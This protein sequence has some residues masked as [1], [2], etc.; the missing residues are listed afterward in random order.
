MRHPN[1]VSAFVEFLNDCATYFENL[2][3]DED[4]MHWAKTYNAKTLRD[5]GKCLEDNQGII[6]YQAKTTEWI[7]STFDRHVV[8]D[9]DERNHRFLEEALELVQAGNCTK[10]EAHKLVDY[11]F[12]RP[13]G[14]LKQEVGGVANT[15]ACLCNAYDIDLSEC[16]GV[17]YERVNTPQMREKIRLKQA[18]KPPMSPLPE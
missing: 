10:E 2:K 12:S 13:V 16:A 18:N 9:K 11:V 3:T 15:L 4:K 6:D 7:N 5:V 17:E 14:E 8:Y 1:A